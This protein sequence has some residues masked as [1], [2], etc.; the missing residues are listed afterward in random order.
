M[1]EKDKDRKAEPAVVIYRLWAEGKLL[2]PELPSSGIWGGC[3]I[4]DPAT[5]FGQ[6]KSQIV[7]PAKP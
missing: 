7:V 3:F 6:F 4:I 2:P 5:I 1:G